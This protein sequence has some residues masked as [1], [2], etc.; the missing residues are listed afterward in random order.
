[1]LGAGDVDASRRLG[2][3]AVQALLAVVEENASG[4]LD[5]VWVDPAS[6]ERLRAL[7]AP[8]V[9]VFCSCPLPELRRRYRARAAQRSGGFDVERPERELWNDRSLRPLAC[10]WPVVTA[11][12]TGDVDVPALAEAVRQATAPTPPGPAPR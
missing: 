12:T 10:G 8:V 7:P 6:V 4:V 9:E 1:V 3:A 11:D 2:A 5:S